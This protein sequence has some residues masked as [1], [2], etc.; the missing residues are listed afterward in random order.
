MQFRILTKC[1]R[2]HVWEQS[3]LVCVW[4]LSAKDGDSDD[5]AV[6]QEVSPRQRDSQGHEEKQRLGKAKGWRVRVHHSQSTEEDHCSRGLSQTSW[7]SGNNTIYKWYN[8][9]IGK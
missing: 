3:E 5:G 2:G 4:N 6:C 7:I 8:S 9:C 1:Y